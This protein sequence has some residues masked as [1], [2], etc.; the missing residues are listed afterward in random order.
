MCTPEY[1]NLKLT[2][3]LNSLDTFLEEVLL[4]TEGACA[5]GSMM[6]MNPTIRVILGY[7]ELIQVFLSKKHRADGMP[8]HIAL[9]YG[10]DESRAIVLNKLKAT[11]KRS[12]K[13]SP[14]L[15]EALDGFFGV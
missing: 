3:T 11:I 12:D 1:I 13:A 4:P 8:A 5:A 2:N 15:V 7:S 14:E 10:R 6:E 9:M